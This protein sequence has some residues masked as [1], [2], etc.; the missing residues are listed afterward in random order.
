MGVSIALTVWAAIFVCARLY[1]RLFKTKSFGWDDGFIAF[2][3][4]RSFTVLNLNL[5]TERQAA[6]IAGLGLTLAGVS[7]GSGQTIEVLDLANVPYVMKFSNF[8]IF[9]NGIAMC[10]MKVGIGISMLRLQLSK[11]FNIA[12]YVA[13]VLSVIVNLTVLF[14]CF[15]TCRPIE[16][17]WNLG[18]EGKCWPKWSSLLFSYTQTGMGNH[19]THSLTLTNVAGNIVTDL[20]FTLGPLY[21]LRKVKVSRYNKWALRG[22]FCIGLL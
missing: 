4:V 7:Y 21:Y 18:V 13:I 14:G 15:A 16:R 3:C 8:A 19:C 12:V 11:R 20:L 17:I 22:V 10:A 9:C 5:L 2:A 6:S 1:T